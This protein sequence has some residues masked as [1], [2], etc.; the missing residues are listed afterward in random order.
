MARRPWMK[1]DFMYP[2]EKLN[3]ARR[4]LM[5]PH[6]LGEA[7]SLVRALEAC[8]RALHGGELKAVE[9]DD[10]RRWVGII[11]RA[12]DTTGLE[13]TNG[14][15]LGKAKAER[16]TQEEEFEFSSAVDEL[17]SWCDTRFL[18]IR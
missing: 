6:P 8:E 14:Q 15:G 18:G 17:A 16:M 12:R 11:E 1:S 3:D 9:D 2:S 5:L 13:D 10:V 4:A 7:D